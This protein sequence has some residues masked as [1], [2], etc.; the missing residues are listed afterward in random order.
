MDNEDKA[1]KSLG[2]DLYK[3]AILNVDASMRSKIST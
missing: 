2:N 3:T 1:K